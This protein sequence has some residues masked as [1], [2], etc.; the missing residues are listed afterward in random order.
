MSNEVKRKRG[1][2]SL[3]RS[4]DRN[5]LLQVA[6][7]AFAT[8]GFD[9]TNIKR[10]AKEAGVAGS[11]FYHHFKNKEGLWKAAMEQLAQKLVAETTA[12]EKILK[13]LDPLS[14]LK[15]ATRQF[16]Y[17]SA[18]NPEFHQ[19]ITYELAR[20]STRADWLVEMVLTPLYLRLHQMLEVLIKEG[21]IKALP[22]ANF[23][24]IAIGAANVYFAQGYQM[25]KLY[26]IDVFEEE[27]IEEH[28]D[29]VIELFFKG[30]L[31]P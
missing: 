11:L 16:I 25:K 31:I 3:K 22:F 23:I 26:D 14:Y 8:Y 17:F 15:A 4:A 1:R 7:K 21:K 28:A 2:P 18:K 24:S 5:Q 9:G 6:L 12:A 13:D 20:P 10:L 19:I 30:L 27:A 29:V